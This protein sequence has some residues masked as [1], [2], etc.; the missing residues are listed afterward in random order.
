MP[1]S[2]LMG[3]CDW[4]ERKEIFTSTPILK[5]Q[6]III[7]ICNWKLNETSKTTTLTN[8]KMKQYHNPSQRQHLSL[9]SSFKVSNAN[10]RVESLDTCTSVSILWHNW[11]HIHE[12]QNRLVG[13][14]APPTNTVLEISPHISGGSH[15]AKGHPLCLQ[16]TL[17]SCQCHVDP[18]HVPFLCGQPPQ[19]R[20][21]TRW[22]PP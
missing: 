2:N 1:L 19:S 7:L 10:S 22:R 3:L 6:I 5:L 16:N 15:P 18:P 17:A 9:V 14:Q 12:K 8:T 21:E 20:F 11:L 4:F 13:A